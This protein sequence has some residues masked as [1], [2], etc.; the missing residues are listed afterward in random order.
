MHLDTYVD[1]SYG[2]D[3]KKGRSITSY[4]TYIAGAP[5][6]WKSHLQSTVADS[7]H[8][9]EYIALHEAAVSTM[10][11]L[12]VLSELGM[13]MDPPTRWEDNDGSR[14]LATSGLGQR[15]ARHLDIKYH[16]VQQLCKERK[17]TIERV[18]GDQQAADILTKGS[19]TAKL[20]THL[21]ELLG[22]RRIE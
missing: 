7:I 21:R 13:S 18:A 8:A 14:R 12:N 11:S 22:V 4:V 17:I 6:V 9:A 19:H 20:Y 16:Y 15:K 10:G 1:S 2:T 5:T 3:P